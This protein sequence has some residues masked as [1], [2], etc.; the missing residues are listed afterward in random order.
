MIIS[1]P[2]QFG[3]YSMSISNTRLSNLAQLSRTGRRCAQLSATR[4]ERSYGSSLDEKEH[5]VGLRVKEGGLVDE[6]Q[7]RVR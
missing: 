6:R 3:Q 1:S 5:L 7:Q 4:S 2:P